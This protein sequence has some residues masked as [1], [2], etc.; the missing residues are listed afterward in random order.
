MENFLKKFFALI[1]ILSILSSCTTHYIATWQNA[2]PHSVITDDGNYAVQ[3]DT[4]GISHAF[5]SRNGKVLV[6][7]ENYSDKPILI[8]LTKSAMTIN[9]KA[10]GYVDGKSTLFGR[11]NQFGNPEFG[12]TGVMDGEIS[13][14]TNT[15]YI[16]PLAYVESEFTDV[17]SETRH[18]V[19]DNFIG[20]RTSHPLFEDMVNAETAFY[21]KNNSPMALS[22][23]INYSILDA[24]N[25]P[26]KT[27]II[28]QNYYLSSFSILRNQ[29]REQVNQMLASRSE[30]S[31]YSITRG[32]T[33]GLVL[34]LAGL[35]ALAVVL[36]VDETATWD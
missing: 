32:Q 14:K 25:Q 36:D 12:S 4:V 15:L 21:Q 23:Y 28:T 24:N 33:T 29:G 5:N 3:N 11:F 22:S 20:T 27:D 8:N 16:P 26:L 13:S 9:G 6:R 7:I 10:Y 2:D 18:L 19:G 35:V 1:F 30:M 17:R 31:G 34:F